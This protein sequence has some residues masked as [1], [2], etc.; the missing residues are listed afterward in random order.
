MRVSPDHLGVDRIDHVAERKSALFLGHARMKH[1]LQQ[2]IAEFLLEVLEIIS[3]DGVGDLVSFL[4][5]V[6]CDGRKRLFKVP[7]SAGLGRAQRCHDIEQRGDL[8]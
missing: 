1:H 8:V 6:G 7:R 3:R 2:Q 4:D 5:G